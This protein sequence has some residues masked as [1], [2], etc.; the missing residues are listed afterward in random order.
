M[1]QSSVANRALE[2]FKEVVKQGAPL[3]LLFLNPR[4]RPLQYAINM[5]ADTI[6]EYMLSPEGPRVPLSRVTE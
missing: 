6:L 4:E 1:L 5:S 3:D 2:A